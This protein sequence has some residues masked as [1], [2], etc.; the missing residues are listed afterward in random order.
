[1][2]RIISSRKMCAFISYVFKIFF[3][4]NTT[5]AFLG[6]GGVNQPRLFCR[7]R[8]T[9]HGI[10]LTITKLIDFYSISSFTF[11][12]CHCFQ[13]NEPE[14]HLIAKLILPMGRF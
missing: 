13:L 5:P 9:F 8:R 3:S 11:F 6:G 2:H 14:R 4:N 10:A 1:M 12:V 7:W